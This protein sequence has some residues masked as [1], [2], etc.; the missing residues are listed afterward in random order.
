MV[1]PM[2]PPPNLQDLIEVVR[3][4]AV[5]GNALDLL[6]TASATVAQIEDTS[7]ALLGYFVDRCRLEGRS[8]SEISAALGV[9]KQAV[10]KRF[11][12]SV[13]DQI[14]ASIPAPTMERFTVRARVVITSAALA[15]RDAGQER[16]SSAYILIGLFAE[17]D[18]IA[19][20]VLQ[21][22]G[23]TREAVRAALQQRQQ[24][25]AGGTAGGGTAADGTAA[26]GTAA[27]GTTTGD[28]AAADMEAATAAAAAAAAAAANDAATRIPR[29]TA[30]GRTVLRDALAI[31]LE[32]G[33]NYIGT[34][35]LLLG[36]YPSETPAAAILRA[37]GASEAD[38]RARVLEELRG[39]QPPP[40]R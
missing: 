11:A 5:T 23:V 1:D 21:A 39:Y 28:T 27:S 17:P 19:G 3:H 15:A 7:D 2:A 8:W 14:I 24:T 30:D 22:L 36:L 13:A 32:L 35:H 12:T 34:E 18:G 38:V 10:H 31:A 4:D 9:T 37:A 6:V 25:A 29:F 20:R 40:R 33:H 26:G 16:V